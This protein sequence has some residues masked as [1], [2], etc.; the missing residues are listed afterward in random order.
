MNNTDKAEYMKG[1]AL[2]FF[3][4]IIIASG[5]AFSVFHIKDLVITGGVQFLRALRKECPSSE[6]PVAFEKY[7]DSLYSSQAWTLDAFSLTQRMLGK[8]EVRNFEVLKAN[9]GAL[10]LHGTEGEID[11]K[12]AKIIADEYEMVFNETNKYGG[13]FLYV[14]APYKN[15]GQAAELADYSPDNTEASET[16]L[17]N[18]IREKGIPVLDLREYRECNGYYNTD[19]HWTVESAFNAS[20]IIADEINRVY[21]IDLPGREYYGDISN[22]ERIKYD[23]CFLGSIGIKVG[24]YFAGRDSFTLYK[25]TFDTSFVFEHYIKDERQFKYSGDFWKTFIDQEMLEDSSYNNKYNANMHGAYVESIIKNEK[26][27][28]SY[29][30]L[31][32]TH[33]YGRPMAQYMCFDF[34][35]LR[36]LDPQE[37]RFNKNLVEYIRDYRPDIV[38]LMYNDLVNVG[39]GN[40][41]E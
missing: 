8:H 30:G 15:V 40:W 19:H 11:K 28:N 7:Y 25:P 36:Y 22:Y 23:D 13:K 5:F 16:Y 10:Y 18:L 37:G 17:D 26:A 39:D 27:L 2:L 38:I 29:K 35:E 6:V 4:L 24:P 14:Q 3:F 32:I 9:N 20:R 1:R 34:S 21:G 33:S 12:T 41:K 31:L